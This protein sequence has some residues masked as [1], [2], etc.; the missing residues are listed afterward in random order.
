VE[1]V[2]QMEEIAQL[3]EGCDFCLQVGQV[4]LRCSIPDDNCWDYWTTAQC[5]SPM[6]ST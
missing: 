2:A 1:D 4:Y 3:K 5:L 6:L